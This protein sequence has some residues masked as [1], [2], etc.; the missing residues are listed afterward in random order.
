MRRTLAPTLPKLLKAMFVQM[1]LLTNCY[2]CFI[3]FT[4]LREG[5]AIQTD[6]YIIKK[7]FESVNSN[8]AVK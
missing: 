5:I 2:S 8:L 7:G 6:T 3:F 4:K 1:N